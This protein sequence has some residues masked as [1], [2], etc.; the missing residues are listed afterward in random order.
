MGILKFKKVNCKNCYKCIRYCPVKAIEVK[1]QQAQI[2]E[3]DCILCGNCIIVCPQNAKEDVNEIDDIKGQIAEGKRVIATVAPSFVAACK[4]ESFK[5]LEKALKELGFAEARETAEGAFL[6]K[7]QYEN[8]V[9]DRW[10][11]AI[12]ST[13]CPTVVKYVERHFPEALPYL[14][15]VISPMEASSRKIREEYKDAVIVFIGPCISKKGECEAETSATDYAITFDELAQW[16]EERNIKFTEDDQKE[17]IKYKSRLFPIAGGIINTMSRDDDYDYIAID[18]F[19]NCVKALKEIVNGNVHNCFIEMSACSGSCIGGPNFQKHDMSVINSRIKVENFAL[20][21]EEN[22]FQIKKD[23]DMY[24]KKRD[25][26]VVCPPPTEQQILGILRKMGKNSR[27]DEL[28]C[29]TCGYATCREKAAAVYWGKA[30]ITM[31]LPFI[32]ERAE[33][34]SD[35]IINITPNLVVA[36]DMDLKV[37]QINR[38]ACDTFGIENEK[39]IIGSPVSRILDEFDFVNMITESKASLKKRTFLVEYNVYLEQVFLFD[40]SNS[41]IICIMKNIT[42]EKKRKNKIKAEKLRAA[43]LADDIV[44]KQLR[45]V[46]E[47]ASLLGETAAETQVA[48]TDLKDTILMEDE[49]N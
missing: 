7:S 48:V 17:N 37:Q 26:Q 30:D 34:F 38:A 3:N 28:N 13:C 11:E 33:S 41:I 29:G 14:A 6:V 42:G 24:D 47:I 32:K 12:V 49:D 43:N 40:K 45:I 36:V 15:P 46:Q 23:I 25:R 5:T 22:D 44:E 2:I 8:L 21:K 27:E 35:K 39:D 1:N 9:K 31:C 20:D 16:M 18:G 19:D 4:V 10:N